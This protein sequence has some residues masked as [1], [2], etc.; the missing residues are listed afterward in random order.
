MI[1]LQD[2]RSFVA[3]TVLL[4]ACAPAESE[5]AGTEVPEARE[6]YEEGEQAFRRADF[7]AAVE[8]F[9]RAVELD[10]TFATAAL[11]WGDASNNVQGGTGDSYERAWRHRDRL[12]EPDRVYLTARLGPNYPDASTTAE[13]VEAYEDAARLAPDRAAIWYFLGETTFHRPRSRAALEQS[14]GYFERALEIDP[15]HSL[16]I[17]HLLLI[18]LVRG[19]LSDIRASAERLAATDTIPEAFASLFA[20][21]ES[22]QA[23][24]EAALEAVGRE[25]WVGLVS[26]ELVPDTWVVTAAERQTRA[27]LDDLVPSSDN[28]GQFQYAYEF[29]LNLGRPNAAEEF[30]ARWESSPDLV[31]GPALRLTNALYSGLSEDVGMAAASAAAERLA[32][33]APADFNGAR[34]TEVMA[35]ELWR[36]SRGDGSRTDETISTLREAGASATEAL[37]MTYEVCALLLEA[38]VLEQNEDPEARATVDRMEE[39]FRQG[40]PGMSV[41]LYN[42]LLLEQA[43]LYERLGDPGQALA[44]LERDSSFQFSDPFDMRFW[45]E[46]GRLSS[47]TGDSDA[48]T[49]AFRHYLNFR[50]DPEP[51]LEAE[52]E[53]VRRAL[54]ALTS[55]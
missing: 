18:D 36:R 47:L 41:N 32:G 54:A 16:S 50:Y 43:A 48:A 26:P 31:V 55:P 30:L 19:D 13:R 39:L 49:V 37:A 8:H 25:A 7:E 40:P 2:S 52:V 1:A 27:N 21:V 42:L 14:R 33:V 44:T 23:G 20:Q 9:R 11:A 45:R 51:G 29:F 6:A 4:V 53:E 22:D 34:R 3:L 38:L 28:F 10:T 5:D 17:N 12:S 15:S 46:R 35:L 24:F